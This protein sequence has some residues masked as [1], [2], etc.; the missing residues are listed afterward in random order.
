EA[1]CVAR[2]EGR[3]S[4]GKA[5]LETEELIFRGEFRLK[6]PLRG[7]SARVDGGALTVT[8]GGGAAVFEIGAAAERWRK[9]IAQP[10]GRL[11][12][13]GGKRGLK[14]SVI[15]VQDEAVRGELLERGVDLAWETLRQGSDMVL[16]GAEDRAALGRIEELKQALAD[17]GALWIVRPKGKQAITEA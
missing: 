7:A 14:V 9:A 12:K 13:L 2:F 15:G 5:L 17:D 16:Y 3:A 1:E 6:I 11:R 4:R 10:K 8:W